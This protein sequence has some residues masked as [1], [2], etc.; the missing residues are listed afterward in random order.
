[1]AD[2]IS[3]RL[4]IS[5]DAAYKSK[6]KEIATAMKGVESE[7]KVVDAQ[8]AKGDR[9][10]AKLTQTYG[11]M[12]SKLDL[13]KQKLNAI[14]AEYDRVVEVEGENS[15]SAAKLAQ[16]Y[17]NASA[18]TTKL[19]RYVK[20][21][22]QELE[23][24]PGKWDKIK[25]RAGEVEEKYSKLGETMQ[26]VGKR[27]AAVAIGA[28]TA[29]IGTSVKGYLDLADAMS[30]VYT[31]ADSGA[32]SMDAMTEATVAA[33]D[34]IG[35][36][37]KEL[38]EAEY[39]AISAGVDTGK[40]VNF[41]ETAAR[42]AVAGLSDTTTVVDASTSIINAW[43]YAWEDATAVLDKMLT[44]QK[45]GKT[46]V[47][48]MGKSIGN[49]TGLAP[50]LGVSLDDIL[51]AT[52]ALTK[53]G[54][55]TT[56]SMTAL[57]GVMTAI[58]KPTSQAAEAAKKI[59]LDFSAAAVQSKGFA[60]FLADVVD[61]TGGDS[62]ILAQLFGNV[63]GLSGVLTLAGSA[64]E[65][66][67]DALKEIGS[68]GG[69]LDEQF[70]ARMASPAKQLE[71]AVN[72]IKN[73]GISFGQTLAPYI[74]IVADKINVI[75]D[76]LRGLTSDQ[77]MALVKTAAWVAGIGAAIAISGK[78]ITSLK[79]LASIGPMVFGPV[80]WVVGGVAACAA[81]S[82]GIVE[83]SKRMLGVRDT[84][85][86]FADSFDQNK[87]QSVVDAL[88]ADFSGAVKV[89][90]VEQA[91]A[92]VQA[93]Y[94]DV[95]GT[96]TDGLPDDAKTM[97]DLKDSVHQKFQP[98][99]NAVDEQLQADIA[100]L[101][102]NDP[103]YEAKVKALTEQ[104]GEMKAH[105]VGV[106][107]SYY[108]FIDTYAGA[109]AATVEAHKS[110]LESLRDEAISVMD[111]LNELS[112]GPGKWAYEAVRAGTTFDEDTATRAWRYIMDEYKLQQ[113]KFE[114]ERDA[115]LMELQKDFAQ[116]GMSEADY[117]NR[118]ADILN[119][120][121]ENSGGAKAA[122][123]Q[124]AKE[125]LQGMAEALADTDPEAALNGARAIEAIDLQDMLLALFGGK[126]VQELAQGMEDTSVIPDALANYI[127]NVARELN[128][129][130][131]IDWESMLQQGG[132][133]AALL[134]T[135]VAQGINSDL[136]GALDGLDENPIVE[137]LQGL[138]QS[139]YLDDLNLDTDQNRASIKALFGNLGT[140]APEGMAEGMSDTSGIET[141]AQD[142]ADAAQ[143]TVEDVLKIHS[144]S[145]IFADIGANVVDGMIQGIQAR[146]NELIRVMAQMARD[147]ANA[148]RN[149]LDIHS[150]SRV[151]Y[152][153]GENTA[154]GYINAI[155][156]KRAASRRAIV[157][158]VRPPETVSQGGQARGGL[159]RGGNVINVTY[160][161]PLG[162]KDAQRFGN[163]LAEGVA[164]AQK[165]FGG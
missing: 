101:D 71:A 84:W 130:K 18:Q 142:M 165:A 47:D 2:V 64:A 36:A 69:A 162:R 35:V 120:Y 157:D 98:L 122:Y 21:L 144:P 3:T 136:T 81:L 125:L 5:G 95:L 31:I 73:A 49:L 11:L 50:Q 97:A 4:E 57:R 83:L 52:A 62:E 91:K 102:P 155:N 124:K 114:D 65:D 60:G 24:Q 80:G 32:V 128:G 1:M 158:M 16:E 26:R 42:G 113:Q 105:L 48:E 44:A 85:G 14:K 67:A 82:A 19:E 9:S 22:N 118:V 152:N 132:A 107:Q 106:E 78:L 46:T 123:K 146:R 51:A 7:A 8:Y 159:T 134:L 156:D 23:N 28:S 76:A 15:A 59:G 147:A 45:F 129:G 149:E 139:G 160:S 54:N 55:N 92:S 90:G 138:T 108:N 140:A 103:A 115:A 161:A 96:L 112:K 141:A 25:T 41:V 39:Q 68:S 143:D 111:E 88:T 38:A 137:Y 154:L 33:S 99:I 77:Q 66:F 127:A 100:A 56:R 110:E 30:V 153:L 104:A 94:D 72:K 131:D 86:D 20:E 121:D 133:G 126:S 70:E 27:I 6:L 164:D 61:K 116:G 148:V 87:V 43:G 13:Q 37:A 145:R 150:P 89:V 53:N 135:R 12:Q 151:M 29:V 109:S 163:V 34:R 79:A 58:V 117:D 74:D 93:A 63:E 10:V 17:N 40:A 119:L 75:G